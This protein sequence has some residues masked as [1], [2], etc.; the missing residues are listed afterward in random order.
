MN[1]IAGITLI[2]LPFTFGALVRALWL[3][4][5]ITNKRISVTGGWLGKDKSQISYSQIKEVRAIPRG[6]GSYGDMVLVLKDDARLEM[7]SI[8][9]FRKVED[10]INEKINETSSRN[11]SSEVAGF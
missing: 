9:N 7:R 11:S 1:L 8:P 3:R 6:F 2:G 5:K 4:F 10:F